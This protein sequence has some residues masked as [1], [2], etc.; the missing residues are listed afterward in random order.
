VSYV[1]N[2]SNKYM[3]DHVINQSRQLRD[4]MV[5]LEDKTNISKEAESVKN[6]KHK[7]LDN[8]DIVEINT[9]LNNNDKNAEFMQKFKSLSAQAAQTS[10]MATY[11]KNFN[12]FFKGVKADLVDGLQGKQR[13]D[14]FIFDQKAVLSLNEAFT[15][16]DSLIKYDPHKG[17][18]ASFN[19][20]YAL[21]DLKNQISALN[22]G[23]MVH[24]ARSLAD[25]AKGIK[26]R[27]E[28]SDA[29]MAKLQEISNNKT[30]ELKEAI[31]NL[32]EDLGVKDK[33]IN[34][35]MKSAIKDSIDFHKSN[36]TSQDGSMIDAHSNIDPGRVRSLLS[37]NN[38]RINKEIDRLDKSL[39]MSFYESVKVGTEDSSKV[40]DKGAFI[41]EF[42]EISARAA[43]T[44]V[45][46][47]YEKNFNDSFKNIQNDLVDAFLGKK[48]GDNFIFDDQTIS[49]LN[50]VSK[51]L[52][53]FIDYDPHKGTPA[54]FNLR[55]AL[56]DLQKQ[57]SSLNDG[58]MLH[59]E[60]S[61]ESL[62]R[63]MMGR[64]EKSD[65]TLE[66][67]Q[68]ISTNA[69]NIL[70]ASI[71][72]LRD[73]AG[74]KDQRINKIMQSAIK[75][76]INFHKINVTSQSGSMVGAHSKVNAEN[77]E[78]LLAENIEANKI[79]DTLDKSLFKSF[80]ESVKV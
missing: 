53:L 68:E 72:N 49:T 80:Y 42:K 9:K 56:E 57:I 55:Y 59:S 70:K 46:A 13:G 41:K 24:S 69:V 64:I 43:Q 73:E 23:N 4:S 28:T 26:N 12:N 50:E 29:T 62:W 6:S 76:S 40:V 71:E 15:K 16:L 44:S 47:A 8:T 60:K 7:N 11:E 79:I 65:A 51:K 34:R 3:N 14:N 31:D 78:K 5:S 36:I 20:R 75:D 35:I 54:S 2:S 48:H 19:S 30:N 32:R 45:M 58:N 27:I 77:I 10:V 38:A 18:P 33:R 63:G 25:L 61:L 66:R 52:E 21:E 74:V 1:N 37:E 39:F 17:T 67:M 22:D